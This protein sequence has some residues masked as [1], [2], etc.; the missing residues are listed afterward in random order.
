MT[1]TAA[2]APLLATKLFV[3]PPRPNRVDRARLR[4][5]L[6]AARGGTVTLA[7]AAAGSGKSTLLADWALS[8]QKRVA[9]LSLDTSDD[10]PSRFL[11]Y[12]IAALRHAGAIASLAAFA[13]ASSAN[14]AAID[15]ILMELLN[16]IA[17]RHAE[18]ALVLDDYHVIESESVHHI[19]Q[20]IIDHIPPNL[21]LVIASR[22]DP[23]LA[24]SRL[25]ARGMLL[26]IRAADLR[27]T[28]DEAARFFNDSMSLGLTDEQVGELEERTEG[29]AVG[30]QLAAISLRGRGGTNNFISSFSGSNRYV[31]DY[32]TDEVLL[33][34]PEDVRTFLL[35]TSVLTQ[36]S[37]PLCNAVTGRN[38]SDRILRL[39]DAGNLFLIGLD[40]VRY[41]YRYHHLFGSLLQ[42]ELER[43]SSAQQIA[44]LHRR[45]S[46]WYLA[47]GMPEPALRHAVVARDDDGAVAIVSEYARKHIM[48]GDGGTVARWISQLPRDRVENDVQLLL[49]H[50]RALTNLYDLVGA[51]DEVNRAEQVMAAGEREQYAGTILSLR[52][53][54]EGLTGNLA[55]S[56]DMLEHAMPLFNEDDFWFSM[57]SLH[58]G[59]T[60]LM[61]PDLRKGEM[62]LDRA[63]AFR[64][65]PD[66]LLTAVVG[67]CYGGSSALWRG[68][69]DLA[70]QMAVEANGWIEEWDAK[71][72]TGRPLASLSHM[73]FAD[74]ERMWNNLDRARDFAQQAMEFGKA[75]FLIGYFEACRALAQI[76]ESQGDWPAA[77]SAAHE[78]SRGCRFSGNSHLLG[79]TQALEYHVVWR[80]GLVT[81]NHDDVNA[82]QRWCE[83]AG[84]LDVAHWRERMHPGLYTDAA[85][86]IGARVLHH[87]KR[88]DEAR[89]LTEALLDEAVRTERVPA[90]ITLLILRSL[91]EA[92]VGS[93][94]AAV[95]TMRRSLDLAT[96]PRFLRPFLDEGSVVLPIIERAAPRV[97]DRDFAL[98]VLSAF[99]VPVK[100][101]PAPAG[102]ADALSERELEVLQLIAAGASNQAAA[103]K[104]FVATSTVK[105]HLEN[106]YAKLGVGGRTQAV[107]RARELHIL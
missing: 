58:L 54:L 47:N 2:D 68:E 3:P 46:A 84:L 11:G 16:A 1:S 72:K 70:M 37:A 33:R 13:E 45:A 39:L 55:R 29:W 32:L 36:L 30:L 57:T 10:A 105:K 98:R 12:V 27:F 91:I 22:V 38:D 31:L 50:A 24:L 8:A 79:P 89:Q 17:E 73:V 5:Q 42:H 34:Q 40:D 86:M 48:A 41:W 15:P 18:T 63:T 6:D 78:M 76:A 106:I 94:D 20:E 64:D 28:T 71:H 81:A 82:V 52:G 21:H 14:P 74:V 95:E 25:R 75:G 93:P 66:G 4:D 69:P 35:E 88:Y 51:R 103:R 61:V 96:N 60:A 87:Q 107:A 83:E 23:P 101:Q 53:I 67:R 97:A 100:R 19:V 85:L 80:R 56:I 65:Q 9:W 59:V 44:G 99:E 102:V 49:L 7:A 92:E 26:E 104:L 43:S 62:Y 77:M 90:Q